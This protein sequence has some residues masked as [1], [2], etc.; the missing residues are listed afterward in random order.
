MMRVGHIGNKLLLGVFMVALGVFLFS[1]KVSADLIWEPMDSFY[2]ENRNACEYVNRAFTTNGPDNMVIVYESP[3]SDKQIKKLD[4]GV[5]L[6][7]SHVYTSP[8]GVAWGVYE[9]EGVTGWFPMDYMNVVYDGISFEEDFGEQIIA[10]EGQVDAAYKDGEIY[11]WSYP[12]CIEG[13]TMKMM[14]DQMPGYT[15]VYVDEQG[16][17]WGFMGYYYGLKRKW[18]CLDAPTADYGTLFP[19]GAA[20]QEMI[21]E[22]KAS[23]EVEK[24]ADSEEVADKE[25]TVKAAE[26]ERIVPEDSGD[27]SMGIAAV[28]VAAVVAV[29]AGLLKKLKTGTQGTGA[30][31]EE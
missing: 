9:E 12:G 18:I 29:T 15:K 14:G 10:E 8:D 21:A 13:N 11:Y 7:V 4:N 3:V 2:E 27:S 23:A 24:S 19:E 25:T 31:K 30:E 16:R 22:E 26:T 5:K 28:L 1:G 17:K 6:Y 20:V